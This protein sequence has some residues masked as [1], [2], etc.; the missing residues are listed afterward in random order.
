MSD[1]PPKI[2]VVDDNR[3]VR[4]LVR[5]TF[6]EAGFDVIDASNGREAVERIA[7]NRPDLVVTDVNMPELDGWG[8]CEAL[9]SDPDTREIPLVFLAAQREVPDRLRGLRLGAHD[10]LCKP[11]STEELLVRVKLILERAGR[12]GG[13]PGAVSRAVLSGHT[14]HMPTP[15]LVQL[16]AINRKT[17]CLRLKARETGRVHFRDGRIV[18]ASTARTRGKKAL[19]RM[20]GWTDAEFEF[21]PSDERGVVD[22]LEMPS[23]RLLMDGLVAIDDLERLRSSLPPEDVPLGLADGATSLFSVATELT[24]T[25][26]EVLRAASERATLRDMFEAG[27]ATDL[28]IARAVARLIEKG[29]LAPAG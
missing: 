14:S 24:M 16:L 8:L 27:D 2:L 28:E 12:A 11:F 29:A 18:A 22:E 1:G 15:D 21:D 26:R 23:Q 9:K 3:L 20:L 13:G 6:L 4:E 7:S 19:F 5:D 17:G 25:E 10:Y